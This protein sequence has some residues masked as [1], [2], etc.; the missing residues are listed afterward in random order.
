MILET[1]VAHKHVNKECIHVS[2][3]TA[4]VCYATLKLTLCHQ[5]QRRFRKTI[6]TNI[7]QGYTTTYHI[8]QQKGLYVPQPW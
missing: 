6:V 4:F 7:Y 3:Y 2:A 5:M 8:Y 1:M